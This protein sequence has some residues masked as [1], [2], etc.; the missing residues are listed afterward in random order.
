L[1]FPARGQHDNFA[2]YER[3]YGD[4][5]VGEPACAPILGFVG[6]R[7]AFASRWRS[8]VSPLVDRRTLLD[9]IRDDLEE[10]AERLPLQAAA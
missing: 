1:R 9:R 10:R 8:A 5:D 7:S 6:G 2:E 3:L 4:S